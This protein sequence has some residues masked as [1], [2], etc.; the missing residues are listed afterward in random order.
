ML[1]EFEALFPALYAV[2]DSQIRNRALAEGI[3]TI[4]LL[5]FPVFRAY[6]C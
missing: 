3:W 6:Y 4:S 5:S 2:L 1:Y